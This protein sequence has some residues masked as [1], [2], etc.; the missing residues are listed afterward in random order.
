MYHFV[1]HRKKE[2]ESIIRDMAGYSQNHLIQQ[3]LKLFLRNAPNVGYS[4]MPFVD[5]IPDLPRAREQGLQTFIAVARIDDI[6]RLIIKLTDEN[7]EILTRNTHRI[8][9]DTLLD[10]D[11]I[12]FPPSRLSLPYSEKKICL[13]RRRTFQDAEAI[14]QAYINFA[15]DFFTP[16]IGNLFSETVGITN[17]ELG[18]DVAEAVRIADKIREIQVDDYGPGKV[19]FM[20][21]IDYSRV[22]TDEFRTTVTQMRDLHPE[23]IEET[24]QDLDE[25]TDDSLD[26]Y[27]EIPDGNID[28]I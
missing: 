8:L 18:Q 20:S 2:Y 16:S 17:L 21:Q 14:L 26:E 19:I 1:T 25:V 23:D 12:C 28:L 15:K 9:E 4:S 11:G 22:I 27:G 13:L 24:C 10:E 5:D 3:A 6:E 7:M